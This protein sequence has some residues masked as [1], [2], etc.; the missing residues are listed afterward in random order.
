MICIPQLEFNP[1]GKRVV[2]HSMAKRSTEQLTFKDFALA[3]AV[4]APDARYEDKLRLAF[5]MFDFDGDKLLTRQDLEQLLRALLPEGADELNFSVEQGKE[6]EK[7]DPSKE[8]FTSDKP[9]TP[10]TPDRQLKLI[11]AIADRVRAGRG[12]RLA[13]P[14]RGVASATPPRALSRP[15]RAGARGGGYGRRR[16]AQL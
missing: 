9:R 12:L 10:S 3:L 2:A 8:L 15:A 6:G 7:V 1:L 13:L 5:D 4:F 11:P 16:S 14:G